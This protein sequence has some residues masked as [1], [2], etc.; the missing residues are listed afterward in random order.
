M[1][2]ILFW[3]FFLQKISVFIMWTLTSTQATIRG[4]P[5]WPSLFFLIAFCCLSS[6]F[7]TCFMST[8]EYGFT[9]GI[10][11]FIRN[12]SRF[13]DN[14]YKKVIIEMKGERLRWWWYHTQN[15]VWKNTLFPPK[16]YDD[17]MM[18]WWIKGRSTFLK[19]SF[20]K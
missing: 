12:F 13:H 17:M 2:L 6:C 10:R 5:D 3:S 11:N 9:L 4:L 20:R 18:I 16:N 19:V 15:K 14:I 7:F 8:L 1:S